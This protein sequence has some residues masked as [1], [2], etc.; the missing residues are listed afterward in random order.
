MRLFGTAANLEVLKQHLTDFLADLEN[1]LETFKLLINKKQVRAAM[2]HVGTLRG[3]HGVLNA[4]LSGRVLELTCTAE[5][6]EASEKVL[7]ANRISFAAFDEDAEDGPDGPDCPICFCEVENGYA[8]ALCGHVACLECFKLQMNIDPKFPLACTKAGC[9]QA[10]A[11]QD[12]EHFCDATMLAKVTQAS[13]R[14]YRQKHAAQYTNCRGVDCDQIFSSQDQFVF[15]DQCDT[16]YCLPCGKKKDVAAPA[17]HGYTCE[18][19]DEKKADDMFAQVRFEACDDELFLT[20][21]DRGLASGE[22]ETCGEYQRGKCCVCAQLF[23][24]GGMAP[25]PNQSCA[26]C[27]LVMLLCLLGHVVTACAMLPGLVYCMCCAV[28]H[29]QM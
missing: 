12:I 28:A 25:C 18:S 17:H 14:A 21:V 15:C 27:W 7:Q 24:Q 2:R 10:L 9:G 23:A 19:L 26:V 29:L 20:R 5:G 6:R 3:T 8:P 1:S 16:D 22:E 11:W 13:F 4:F